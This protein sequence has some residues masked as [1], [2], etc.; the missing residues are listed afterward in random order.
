VQL[1]PGLRCVF[2]FRHES[3]FTDEVHELLR[4][5]NAA[6][7]IADTE[8]G[9]TPLVA[10]ADFGYFRLHDEG[11]SADDLKQWSRTMTQLGARTS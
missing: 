5:R 8:T 11:Y 3:W 7:C 1:P 6:L 10:T 9:T 2:E 4:T